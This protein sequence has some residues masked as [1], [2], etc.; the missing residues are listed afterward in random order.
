[1]F[2]AGVESPLDELMASVR[3]V[4]TG[5][6]VDGLEAHVAARV[7]EQCAEAERLLAALRVA[8]TVTLHDKALW[9]REGFRS[10]AAWMASKTGTAVGTAIATLDMAA[11]LDDLPTL[12]AAFRA[13]RL[14][15]AQARLIAEVASEVPDAEEQLV[16][17][18]GKLTLRSLGEECRRVE[19][20]AV[21]NEDDRYRRVHRSRHVRSWVDRHGV[22]RLNAWLT[23]DEL[24]RLM[25]DVDRRCDEM[26][27]DAIRGGWFE[28]RE[29]HRADALVDLARP[30][31]A[32]PPGPDT[33][34]HVVVDHEAL[35]RGHTVAG[36]T[37]E[38]PGIGPIPVSVARRLGEDAILKVLLTNGVDVV[39]VAHGGRTI[40]AH[41]RSAL[42]VRDPKCIVPRCD[43]RRNLEIDHRDTFGRT[44]V[45]KL[46]QLARLCRWHHHQKTFL[47]YT[48][49][50]GP[51]T[52]QWIPPENRD[53]DLSVLRRI[54]TTARRC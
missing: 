18:A 35:M 42:E 8:A 13:G 9:R 25:G 52:W 54:I 53:E 34:V 26:V 36:E 31:S 2:D 39:G 41:L 50:G 27:V 20:A 48:Y 7:V 29:A 15:E 12:A 10:A 14:S 46:D 30:D 19:A 40:A 5:T 43:V 24:G 37:C 16:E 45:T 6:E 3:S 28:S 4:V 11:Q 23:P 22:G 1:M 44:G 49:R 33:M 38:I 32:A 21:V 47:G 51:G 17:A